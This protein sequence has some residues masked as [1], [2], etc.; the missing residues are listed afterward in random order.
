MSGTTRPTTRR[1]TPKI[2]MDKQ[3]NEV[4]DYVI[5][6]ILLLVTKSYN[7]PIKEELH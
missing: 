2:R 5:V 3:I 7:L 6:C 1:H 4:S